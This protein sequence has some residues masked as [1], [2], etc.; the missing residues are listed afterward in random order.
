MKICI[1][2]TL[3]DFITVHINSIAALVCFK[4]CNSLYVSLNAQKELKDFH[5]T[6][7]NYKTGLWQIVL[8][9]DLI[10]RHWHTYCYPSC[11]LDSLLQRGLTSLRLVISAKNG[12]GK[13]IMYC[14]VG[15]PS[16]IYIHP[17][18]PHHYNNIF[19]KIIYYHNF[20]CQRT[21]NSL[22]SAI[23][24]STRYMKQMIV[25]WQE[26]SKKIL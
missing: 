17:A 3:S 23:W 7:Q 18:M 8:S 5:A 4:P 22:W 16:T 2:W 20:H 6:E 1:F 10:D 26:L 14:R 19:S 15:A 12:L 13:I 24:F 25:I 21:K 11:L 9:S